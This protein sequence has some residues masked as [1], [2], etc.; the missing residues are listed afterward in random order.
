V[1]WAHFFGTAS[2]CSLGTVY[3]AIRRISAGGGGVDLSLQSC[4]GVLGF[5][6]LE[7]ICDNCNLI[8]LY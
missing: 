5:L 2:K 3:K 4:V 6:I 8:Q 7:L 1:V